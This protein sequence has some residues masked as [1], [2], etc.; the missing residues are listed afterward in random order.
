MAVKGYSLIG[1]FIFAFSARPGRRS[2][3][4]GIDARTFVVDCDVS[5]RF[6]S[7]LL[8]FACPKNK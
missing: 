6:F 7:E 8:F 3:M 5:F 2:C 1:C 4:V